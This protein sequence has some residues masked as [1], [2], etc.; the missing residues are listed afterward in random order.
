M[1]VGIGVELVDVARFGRLL[2]RHGERIACRV[3]TSGEQAYAAR[4]APRSAVQSLA[5]RFA[6]KI[7]ARRALGSRGVALCEVE[8]VR[9]RG[10]PPSLRFHAGAAVQAQARGVKRVALTLTHDPVCCVGHV[11]LEGEP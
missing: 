11:V 4:R 3:F 8:V 10:G 7:A 2:E 5:V 9:A 6:A 1:I